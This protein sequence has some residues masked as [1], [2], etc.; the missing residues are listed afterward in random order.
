MPKKHKKKNK[1]LIRLP[2]KFCSLLFRF[3]L[4]TQTSI[5]HAA[6]L[7]R[8]KITL[9]FNTSSMKYSTYN[10]I[11]TM[12]C[13]ERTELLKVFALPVVNIK[14]V[15]LSTHWVKIKAWPNRPSSTK[16]RN[17]TTWCETL[18]SVRSH[19]TLGGHLCKGLGFCY[20]NIPLRVPSEQEV[21]SS[22]L[23]APGTTVLCKW[24]LVSTLCIL[25]YCSRFI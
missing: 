16:K 14:P 24:S 13:E 18:W 1:I 15:G 10:N 4:T 5:L 7:Q 3:F 25:S 22:V 6:L 23:H 20:P 8:S 2:V 11:F 17:I 21:H 12:Q 9:N 19:H